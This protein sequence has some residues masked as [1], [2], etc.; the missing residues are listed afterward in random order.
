MAAG[1]PR[2]ALRN[3]GRLIK[4]PTDLSAVFP[5]GGTELGLVHR[6]RWRDGLRARE[7]TAE[8][9]GGIAV[10]YIVTRTSCGLVAVLRGWDDDALSAV[11][12]GVASGSG[13]GRAVYSQDSSVEAQRAGAR[14]SDRAHVLLFAPLATA[15]HPAVLIYNAV[16]V[17]SV[18]DTEDVQ[19]SL[20]A[21]MDRAV[22]WRGIPDVS[23]RTFDV[24]L[25]E[26]LS[27]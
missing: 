16:P 14:L 1:D 24:A 18:V 15:E 9:W 13:S 5:Y 21:E 22:A 12:P 3:P 11:F 17:P 8:E 2:A 25:L 26:D 10:E 4:D 23:K 19:L 6:V 20:D 7:V 27:L